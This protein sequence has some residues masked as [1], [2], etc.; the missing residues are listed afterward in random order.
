MAQALMKRKPALP[1]KACQA[2]E[3]LQAKYPDK[4]TGPLAALVSQGKAEAKCQ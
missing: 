4:V 2:Y 3:V 1:E